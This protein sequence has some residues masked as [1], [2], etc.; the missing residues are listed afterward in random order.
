MLYL[1]FNDG[2]GNCPH[3][4]GGGQVCEAIHHGEDSILV[5]PGPLVTALVDNEVHAGGVVH[6]GTM[7]ICAAGG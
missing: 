2:F 3:V 5:V 6:E 1:F 4:H 7:L